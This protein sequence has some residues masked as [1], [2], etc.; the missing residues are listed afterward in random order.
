[1]EKGDLGKEALKPSEAA[2][3]IGVG[4][5]RMREIL[6]SGELEVV[7][8]GPRLVRIPV[9]SLRAWLRAKAG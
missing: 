5:D 9:E 7:R 3:V 2:A 4:K 6:A 1:M 8:L